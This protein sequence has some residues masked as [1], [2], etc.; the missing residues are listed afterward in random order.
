MRRFYLIFGVVI[1]LLTLFAASDTLFTLQVSAH[2]LE[3]PLLQGPT[4]TPTPLDCSYSAVEATATIVPGTIDIDNHC[5]DCISTISL[6]FPVTFYGQQ[7]SE[8]NVSSNGNLQFL[9]AN[10]I[11]FNPCL[12]EST[13]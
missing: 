10:P 2:P 11:S 6:P 7:C 1:A 4:A 5:D 8:A 9:S 13:F 12:P 3:A